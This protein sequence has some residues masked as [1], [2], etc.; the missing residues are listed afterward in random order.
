MLSC[1][2]AAVLV[3]SALLPLSLT[4]PLR[5]FQGFTLLQQVLLASVIGAAPLQQQ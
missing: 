1:T 2:I 4:T 3:I 5:S